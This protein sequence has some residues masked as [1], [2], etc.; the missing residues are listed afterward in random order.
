MGKGFRGKKAQVPDAARPGVMANIKRA[1][2]K[3]HPNAKPDETPSMVQNAADLP[4]ETTETPT[5]ALTPEQKTQ[6]ITNLSGCKCSTPMP[7]KGLTAEQLGKLSDDT[8]AAYDATKKVVDAQPAP[9][10]VVN[11]PAP[12]PA[13][14]P[15]VAQPVV[16]PLTTEQQETLAWAYQERANRKAE[17]VNRL[18]NHI[19]DAAQKQAVV[20]LYNGHK[21]EELLVLTTTMPAPTPSAEQQS[22]NW[23]PAGGP[24]ILNR[25]VTEEPLPEPAYD[26]SKK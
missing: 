20:N 2:K 18:T 6:I 15:P 4:E 10:T 5:M 21:L 11:T 14:P 9:T 7:W 26:F 13:P 1:W 12:A 24:Q 17:L 19:S 22:I 8:L 23:W 25:E 3:F 16:S